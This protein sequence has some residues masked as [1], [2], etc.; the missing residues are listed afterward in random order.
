[1][2]ATLRH[3]AV[4]QTA[5]QQTAAQQTA[6][7]TAQQTAVQRASANFAVDSVMLRAANETSDY[8]K[9][10]RA[11]RRSTI[12]EAAVCSGSGSSNSTSATSPGFSFT[13]VSLYACI[14]QDRIYT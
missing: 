3:Q 8:V 4:Q 14:R 2:R 7:L 9:R 12:V 13:D 1:M 5:A 6:A 11:S 10:L